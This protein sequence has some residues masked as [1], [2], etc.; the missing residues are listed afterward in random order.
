MTSRLTLRAGRERAILRHHPW[1]F[2]G[3]VA[4]IE[5]AE[6]IPGGT[7]DVFD[8]NGRW[9]ARAAYSPGSRI[10]ARIWTHDEDEIVDAGLIQRRL[11]R[12]VRARQRLAADPQIEA[13]REV[14]AESDGLPG[15]IV[16]RY[17]SFRVVQFLSAG[18]E[19][20]REAILAALANDSCS[21]IFERSDAEARVLEGLEPKVGLV[22]GSKPDIRRASTWISART[23]SVCGA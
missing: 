18:A 19:R 21:G 11:A 5:G 6:P 15:L 7:L 22:W 12:A 10:R 1:I 14:H 3:A 2:S 23:D 13:H 20:W 17:G 16:D 9:L 4:G 8:A